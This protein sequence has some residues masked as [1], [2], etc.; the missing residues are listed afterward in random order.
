MLAN[1]K[2][3]DVHKKGASKIITIGVNGTKG[4][5]D[6]VLNTQMNDRIET[7]FQEGVHL[8]QDAHHNHAVDGRKKS[9]RGYC[10]AWA[11]TAL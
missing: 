2:P 10:C 4:Q 7:K 9:E 11:A 3:A 1:T 6:C 8:Q 5:W